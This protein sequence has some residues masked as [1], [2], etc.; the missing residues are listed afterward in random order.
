MVAVV[1]GGHTQRIPTR[2]TTALPCLIIPFHHTEK[3][4][5][6]SVRSCAAKMRNIF[7]ILNS[8]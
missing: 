4:S 2:T 6:N 5:A 7:A 1:T 8:L 3:S